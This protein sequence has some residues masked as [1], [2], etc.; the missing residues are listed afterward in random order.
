[1]FRFNHVSHLTIDGDVQIN[2]ILYEMLAGSG[3]QQ[4][5]SAPI[6]PYPTSS[7]MGG[8]GGM[9]PYP[10]TSGSSFVPPMPQYNP[11]YNPGGGAGYM[12]T[13]GYHSGNQ[14]YPTQPGGN[15]D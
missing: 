12:P 11:Q 1:M 10:T 4:H 9:P 15:M 5:T 8:M 2:S 14:P 13:P 6:P 7:P 3:G